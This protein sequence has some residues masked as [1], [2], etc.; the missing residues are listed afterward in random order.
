MFRARL[1]I[2][3]FTLGASLVIVGCAT[4]TEQDIDGP[5]D[6]RADSRGTPE[7]PKSDSGTPLSDSASGDTR[8]PE[9]EDTRPPEGEDT[10]VDED[11]D[12]P[13]TSPPDTG[14]ITPPD[15][16]VPDTGT[17]DTGTIDTGTPDT[18][19]PPDGG[20]PPPPTL[21]PTAG[22]SCSAAVP[23]SLDITCPQ[24]FSGDSCKGS[25]LSTSCGSGQGLIYSLGITSGIRLY[26][27]SVSAGFSLATIPGPPFCGG[28][29]SC[30]GPSMYTGVSAGSTQWWTVAKTG[31]GCGTYTLTITPS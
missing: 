19:L 23:V 4:G 25:T 2:P 17:P 20:C 27:I 14:T 13:D 15:T 29:G 3:G 28:A 1:W 18:A 9:G 22:T 10:S 21:G 12:S 31:G 24:T 26:S 7:D 6:A 5:A 30:V 16:S 8:P 11:T